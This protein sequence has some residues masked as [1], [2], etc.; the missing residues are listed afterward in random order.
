MDDGR[1]RLY[2]ARDGMILGVCRGIAR[3]RDLPVAAV[4]IAMIL[5]TVFTGFWPGAALYFLAGFLMDLEPALPP[6]NSQESDFYSRFQGSRAV[7]LE[8]LRI[9]MESLDK[10]LRRMEDKVTQPGFDWESRMRHDRG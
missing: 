5:L 2:R 7:A 1:H 8:E 10:R 3:Y 6:E 4:R 9:K